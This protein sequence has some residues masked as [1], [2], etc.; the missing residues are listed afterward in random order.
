MNSVNLQ[1][2]N[3]TQKNQLHFYTLIMNYLKKKEN[4]SI[5]YFIK[6]NKIFKTE[7][8]QGGEVSVH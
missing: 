6:K 1:H 8:N 2:T 5:Y 3:S 7:F 4:D